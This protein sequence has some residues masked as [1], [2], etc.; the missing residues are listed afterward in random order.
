MQGSTV[1]DNSSTRS[2]SAT[3][4]S[5]SASSYLGRAMSG[6]VQGFDG[7]TGMGKIKGDDGATYRFFSAGVIAGGELQV[8]QKVTFTESDGVASKI[9]ASPS[10]ASSV[11]SIGGLANSA[12]APIGG[13]R[14]MRGTVQVFDARTGMGKIKGNDGAMYRFFSA[15]VV[16]GRAV[17]PG[18]KVEFTETDGVATKI[19]VIRRGLFRWLLRS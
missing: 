15:G 14:P 5:A 16:G 9:S 2:V 6:I 8:G 18:R 7:R 11:S 10:A 4:N 17:A 1:N 12:S 19:A 13:G 3:A